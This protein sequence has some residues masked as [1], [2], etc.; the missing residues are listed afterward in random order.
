MFDDHETEMMVHD[1]I[2]DKVK[3][4][5]MVKTISEPALMAGMLKLT[6]RMIMSNKLW[7]F[8]T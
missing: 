1:A 4:N 7:S 2:F 3:Y 8:L 5:L 6:D